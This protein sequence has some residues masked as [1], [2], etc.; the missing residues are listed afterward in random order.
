MPK[1]KNSKKKKPLKIGLSMGSLGRLWTNGLDQNTV[2]LAGLLQTDGF[3]VSLILKEDDTSKGKDKFL[4]I[5]LRKIKN[6][7]EFLKACE[8]LDVVL[9]VS[10]FLGGPEIEYLRK[11]GVKSVMID[12]GNY[13]QIFNECMANEPERQDFDFE[14]YSD[15]DATW[16]SPHFER[17]IPW[18][19]SF[20]N[21]EIS[22]CPYIWNPVFFDS[23]CHEFKGDPKWSPEKNVKK[24]AIHE[25][26][27]NAIKTCVIPLSITSALNKTNPELVEEVV[28]LNTSNL[29]DSKNF[30]N[31][32]K[33]LGLVKKGSFET[34]RTTPWMATTGVMGLSLFHH[35]FNGLNY[36][37]MELLRLGYPVVHNSEFFKSAG[38]FYPEIDVNAGV[39][40]LK[41]AIE[42]HEDNLEEQLEASDEL[43]YKYSIDNPANIKGYREL[44]EKLFDS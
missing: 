35:T 38:Y 33:S 31:Y 44:I 11:K 29:K 9:F 5:N 1:K 43:L 32:I 22:V 41:L 37:P 23:K 42:N 16:V 25:P 28:V 39:E 34:R 27:I 18:Y 8:D 15:C 12:Y 26:N 2:F 6:G 4:G 21:S 40:Q 19:N 24:I 20:S 10:S 17:N 13:Y 30:V 14:R 7:V 3:D 36:L